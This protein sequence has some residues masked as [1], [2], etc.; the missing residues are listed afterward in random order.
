MR[1]L[2]PEVIIRLSPSYPRSG[3]ASSISEGRVESYADGSP[4]TRSVFMFVG[5]VSCLGSSFF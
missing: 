4:G 2:H 3:D 5:V 1:R